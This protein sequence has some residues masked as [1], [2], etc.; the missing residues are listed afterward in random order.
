MY[1][2]K[3]GDVVKVNYNQMILEGVVAFSE[4]GNE[5][6]A[7][8][9]ENGHGRRNILRRDILEAKD[10]SGKYAVRYNNKNNLWS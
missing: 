5:R 7:I 1:N 8:Y 10:S 4:E 2:L 6:V 3:S 9:L